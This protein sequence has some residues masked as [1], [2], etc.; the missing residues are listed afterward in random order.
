MFTYN[1]AVHSSTGMTPIEVLTGICG[2]LRINVDVDPP[3]GRVLNVKERVEA[4]NTMCEELKKALENTAAAQKK[5][6][7]KRH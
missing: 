5:Q 6:Y 3:E 1:N 2:D 7:N 4:L